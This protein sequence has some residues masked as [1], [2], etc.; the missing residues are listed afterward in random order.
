MYNAQAGYSNLCSS[1]LEHVA[2]RAADERRRS[3]SSCFRCTLQR[4][5]TSVP[6]APPSSR[7]SSALRESDESI[8]RPPP[9]TLF[10]ASM[11]SARTVQASSR[12]TPPACRPARPHR[13]AKST[14]DGRR[15]ERRKERRQHSLG[16]RRPSQGD[17]GRAGRQA[18]GSTSR[19]RNPSHRSTDHADADADA[20]VAVAV[21]TVA[22]RGCGW[23]RTLL[24]VVVVVVVNIFLPDGRRR[25]AGTLA[26]AAEAA[27]AATAATSI[28]SKGVDMSS[29]TT[30]D[31]TCTTTPIN[32]PSSR[33]CRRPP[34][35]S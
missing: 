1:V 31:T 22:S 12:P 33:P 30:R 25:P 2:T 5:S 35:V 34:S 29:P 17:A 6:P 14:A 21:A 20:A 18:G 32:S 15:A 16:S 23:S 26:A 11:G 13:E 9:V 27:A 19:Q 3:G 8:D 10:P 28:S 7:T 24:L 4:P